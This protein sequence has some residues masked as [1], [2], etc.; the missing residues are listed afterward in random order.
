MDASCIRLIQAMT[1]ATSELNGKLSDSASGA[2]LQS[3]R[4]GALAS[5]SPAG[6][7]PEEEFVAKRMEQMPPNAT[8]VSIHL[9]LEKAHQ[10]YRHAGAEGVSLHRVKAPPSLRVM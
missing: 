6:R 1:G 8:P 2:L 3:L 4:I 9:A 10:D 7:E 5:Q